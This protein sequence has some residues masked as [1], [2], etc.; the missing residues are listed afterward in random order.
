MT[1]EKR[2]ENARKALNILIFMDN[3]KRVKTGYKTRFMILV[4]PT[5]LALSTTASHSRSWLTIPMPEYRTPLPHS[6]FSQWVK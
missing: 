1:R 5:H 6:C 3:E 2:A 4:H